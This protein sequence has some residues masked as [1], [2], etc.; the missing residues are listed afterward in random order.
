MPQRVGVPLRP[1]S[2]LVQ[3]PVVSRC[4]AHHGTGRRLTLSWRV[5]LDLLELYFSY[6]FFTMYLG[7]LGLLSL[8]NKDC[9]GLHL[10]DRMSLWRESRK[11]ITSFLWCEEWSPFQAFILPWLPAKLVFW[12]QAQT[13]A[14]VLLEGLVITIITV[15]NNNRRQLFSACNL[16]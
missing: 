9:L 8:L 6:P 5:E 7:L 4:I 2:L 15:C 11:R 13:Q 12:S 3:E 1:S 10:C 14:H 16:H